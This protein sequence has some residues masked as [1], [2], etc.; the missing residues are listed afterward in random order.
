MQV[1]EDA[2]AVE[3]ICRG[4]GAFELR[5]A[6]DE[7]ERALLWRG[8]KGAFPAMGRMSPD[9]YV[10][11]GVVPRTRLPEVLRRIAELSATSTACGSA[12]SFTRA[13]ATCTRSSSTTPSRA[14][15]RRAK[16]LA[17]A[18]LTACLDAGGSLTGEHGVGVDKACAMP[19]MFSER[20]LEAFGRLRRAFDPDGHRQPGQGA[21]D[22][23]ALR[24]DPGPVPAHPLERIGLV[25]RF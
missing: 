24:R 13:T 9:Y 14:R 22:A 20:D 5:I 25:E 17:E 4:C 21:A 3:E 10:Q 6:K 1:A 19:Q 11:D 12:T 23:T 7:A 18:I 15:R 2:A 16:E 8:R